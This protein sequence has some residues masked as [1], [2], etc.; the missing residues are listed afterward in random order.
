M[1]F[2]SA[3]ASTAVVRVAPKARP[4]FNPTQTL[5]AP[6]RQPTRMPAATARTVNSGALGL[7]IA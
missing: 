3:K 1:A 7:L 6:I 2:T 5:E 4:I